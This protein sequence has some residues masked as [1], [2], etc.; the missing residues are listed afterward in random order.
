MKI[1]HRSYRG[2]SIRPSPVV[3][4]EEDGGLLLIVTPWGKPSVAEKSIETVSDFILSSRNDAEA[5]SPFQRMTCL[6]PLANNVR[7]A[8]MLLN[9]SI[10]R[11]VNK[12][13]YEGGIEVLICAKHQGEIVIA[14]VGQP[15]AFINRPGLPLAPI[16]TVL[17][18]SME[19]S[20]P[21]DLLP[22]LPAQLI[23]VYSTSNFYV[24]SYHAHESDQ[25]IFL[26][27]SYFPMEFLNLPTNMRTLDGMTKLLSKDQPDVPFWLATANV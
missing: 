9:D 27:R 1:T 25:L 20:Q 13:D 24:Q 5:T 7:V 6:S 12:L 18:M 4:C 16:S 11:E 15:H 22:P 17:D 2:K 8:M 26:S 14:Q 21:P 3:H 10:Y 23:G 19:M